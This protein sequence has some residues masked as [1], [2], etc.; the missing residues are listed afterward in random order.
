MAQDG[1]AD[2]VCAVPLQGFNQTQ[3]SVLDIDDELDFDLPGVVPI[4]SNKGNKS[5]LD[6]MIAKATKKQFK[7]GAQ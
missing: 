5:S 7:F 3:P 6:S 1:A 2:L 4:P